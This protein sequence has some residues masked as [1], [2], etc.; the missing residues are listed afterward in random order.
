M[1][2]QQTVLVGLPQ[3]SPSTGRNLPWTM[4]HTTD[5]PVPPARTRLHGVI[6]DRMRTKDVP[7]H[8]GRCRRCGG[9]R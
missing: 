2:N 3:T 1:K 6:Y 8:V 4:S 7:A 5:C 9:G